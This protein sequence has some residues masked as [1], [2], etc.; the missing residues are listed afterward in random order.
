MEKSKI[1][2]TNAARLLDRAKIP[3]ELI[4]YPVGEEHMSAEEVARSIG[5]D[6]TCVYKTIVLHGDRSG[7]FVCVVRGDCEIDLKAAAKASGNKSAELIHLKELF[8]LTGYVRGGC[9]PIGMK[10][11][12]PT[13]FQADIMD[14]PFV[15]VSAGQRGL[16]FRIAP[17]ELVKFTRGKLF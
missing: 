10:K 6:I 3:Y 16:Q 13:Y 12:F 7:Y 14:K 15:Y 17:A 11:S 1:Q 4:R 8:P 2:K 9:S 5:E